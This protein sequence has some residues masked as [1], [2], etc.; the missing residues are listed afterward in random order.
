MFALFRS[1][2]LRDLRRHRGQSALIIASI[3]LGVVAWTTTWSLNSLLGIALRESSTPASGAGLYISNAE[4][5][6]PGSLSEQV[7]QVAGVQSARPIVMQR[8]RI[9]TPNQPGQWLSAMLIGLDL[10]AYQNQATG[11]RIRI[12]EGAADAFLDQLT[13]GRVPV[14]AA[15]ELR[16]KYDSAGL[17]LNAVVNGQKLPLECVGTLESTENLSGLDG[18]ILITG[19]EEAAT[20]CGHPGRVSRIDVELAPGADLQ[21]VKTDIAAIVKNAADVMTPLEQEGRTGES[22]DALRAGFSLCGLG[23]LGLA[24]FL[25]VTVLG[26]SV[27]ER[28]RTIGLLR[29]LGC[30]RGQMRVQIL[31]EALFLGSFG[32]IIGVA[33]GFGLARLIAGP[34]LTALGDVFLPLEARSVPLDPAVAFGG[35]A[36]GLATSLVAALV[37]ASRAARLSPTLAMKREQA[38][39]A[40]F[41]KTKAL[42]GLGLILLAIG[43]FATKTAFNDLARVYGT[44]VCALL[45]LIVLIPLL[46]SV[47]ARLIRPAVELVAGLPGRLAV[48]SLIRSPS[49]TGSTIAGLAGGVALMVQTGGVIQ[50]NERAVRQWVD[51]CICGDLFVTS[52]GPMSASGRT[53][54]M[55]NAIGPQIQATLPG[56][57][58]VAMKFVHL[59]W[60]SR[61]QKT[62]LLMLALDAADYLEMTAPRQP[63]L[64]D[65]ALYEKLL[66]P[67]TALVSENFSAINGLGVGSVVSLPGLNGDIRLKIV[68]TVVDFS[69]NRGTIIVDRQ[70]TGQAF[71]ATKVDHFAVGLDARADLDQNRRL[72]T[73]APW[74]VDSAIEVMTRPALRG[75]ILGMIRSLYGVAYVQELVAAAVAALGVSSSMLI[76][77]MQ[78][79]R[80]IAL[81][82]AIG[83]TA[84]QLFVTVLAE[85]LIMALI[86]TCLGGLIGLGLEWYVLRVVL[87]METGF[88]FPVVLPWADFLLIGAVIGLAALVAGWIPALSATRI[89]IGIALARD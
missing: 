55:D 18:S 49:R 62:K 14:I 52:G 44:L 61:N 42:S 33:A 36:A 32:S 87:L 81:L 37:P 43:L 77:V 23:A 88:N 15:G 68:G 82:R 63:P 22:L 29:S 64:A 60:V 40:T 21:T 6:L 54:P 9:S 10:E 66:E 89:R 56:A 20:V 79:R 50:G 30:T 2:S 1:L 35:M 24:M 19:Y 80:E 70:G 28:S 78:R 25:I 8:I 69:N 12:S 71:G 84:N 73:E 51:Q 76:C 11:G 5:G 13:Q 4:I 7:A 34:L 38:R 41:L 17:S 85:A 26:V 3:A 53:I 75:H 83:S 59:D 57:R 65:R 39:P 67:N 47:L 27:S 58:V 31:G 48:E 16:Q 74:A 46:T 86:G 45:G 72:L